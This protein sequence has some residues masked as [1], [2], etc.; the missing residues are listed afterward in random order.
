MKMN[1][2][3]FGKLT[4]MLLMLFA[5]L[6]FT[7][8]DEETP[9]PG[10]DTTDVV[11]DE[12]DDT[13]DPL[14]FSVGGENVN[15]V[16]EAGSTVTVT[17]TITIPAGESLTIEEGV[18]VI[19][20]GDGSIDAPEIVL[21]GSLYAYGTE[22]NP[23]LIS[24]KPEDRTEANNFRGLWGGI[25]ATETVGDL[26]LEYTTIEYTGAPAQPGSPVVAEGEIDEGE[27]RY[28]IYM[29]DNGLTSNFIMWHS[30]IAYTKDDAIRL[31]G[32]KTLIAYS[33][34]ELIGETGGECLNAKSGTVGDFAF[35][36]MYSSATN[37]LKVAN[38]KGREPQA[39]NYYYNNTIVNSGWRRDKAGRGG[40]LNFENGARGK[41]FNNL[42]VNSRFGLRIVGGE[43]PA[44]VA[45]IEF[46]FNYYFGNNQTIV[47]EFHPSVGII[48]TEGLPIPDSDVFGGVNE[49]NPMFAAYDL[50]VFDHISAGEPSNAVR[51]QG[52]FKLT[53][54][55][56]A[57]SGAKT[58]FSPRFDSYEANG[59]TYT[60]PLPAAHFGA[61]GN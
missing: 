49:N 56:P 40:S 38:S 9:A 52:D 13:N 59:K 29:Q 31:N 20:A 42:V 10:D 34:F 35:N 27:P 55:S 21:A 22:A 24:A 43:E 53:A 30:R 33:E 12:T 47:G 4:T 36:I 37:G 48:G 2:L 44:D 26:V 15:G 39:D 51:M 3:N 14:V 45:N 41:A 19:M 57:S 28:A 58:D 8:C 46:G 18:E 25:L 17:A 11:D 54:N 32:A 16:W 61:L 1:V 5:F 6:V 50:S 23:I 7:A 60:T